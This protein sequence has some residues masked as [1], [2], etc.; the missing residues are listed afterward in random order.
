MPNG[1]PVSHNATLYLALSQDAKDRKTGER[2]E[3]VIRIELNEDGTVPEGTEIPANDELK[4][5]GT[6]YQVVVH[7]RFD[8]YFTEWLKIAGPTPINLNNLIPEAVEPAEV[9]E[10]PEPEVEPTGPP[11]PSKRIRGAKYSGFCPGN[12]YGA[13]RDV[14]ETAIRCG[15]K[16]SRGFFLPYKAVVRSVGLTVETVSQRCS[17]S[18]LVEL[19]SVDDDKRVCGATINI[20]EPGLPSAFLDETVIL[21]PGEYVLR[22][23]LGAGSS[24]LTVK[25]IGTDFPMICFCV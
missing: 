20:K 15:R 13:V 8:T 19:H 4:P 24:D 5:S 14:G 7:N 17:Y 2:V 22:W 11:L 21:N 25:T 16:Y 3:R 18:V 6:C 9:E 23:S 10:E 12:M 1:E